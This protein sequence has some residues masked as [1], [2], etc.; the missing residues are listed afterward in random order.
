MGMNG[1]FEECSDCFR[2]AVA[3]RREQW[4][5]QILVIRK[6]LPFVIGE[7]FAFRKVL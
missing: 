2:G 5:L 6:Y 3:V 7:T 1:E 4:M